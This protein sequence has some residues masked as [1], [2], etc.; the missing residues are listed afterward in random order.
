MRAFAYTSSNH[1]T[2]AIQDLTKIIQNKNEKNLVGRFHQR[3]TLYFKL[4][5]IKETMMDLDNALQLAND[6]P[7]AC[8]CYNTKAW[9]LCLYKQPEEAIKVTQQRDC[10]GYSTATL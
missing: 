1:L 3:A 8:P 9:I 10:I 7:G 5:K 4:G 2:E 6:S